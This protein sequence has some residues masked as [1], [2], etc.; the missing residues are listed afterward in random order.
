MSAA[1]FS[2]DLQL[3]CVLYCENVSI[4]LVELSLLQ[5][6]PKKPSPCY[7]IGFQC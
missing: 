2:V 5:A 4:I 3:A 6:V 7:L 1:D